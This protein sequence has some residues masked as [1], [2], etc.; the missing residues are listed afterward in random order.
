MKDIGEIMNFEEALKAM[1]DGKKVRMKHW[2]ISCSIG[3]EDGKIYWYSDEK[4][5]YFTA[6]IS[7]KAITSDEWGICGITEE[8]VYCRCYDRKPIFNNGK[9]SEN[10]V[11][12]TGFNISI[13]GTECETEFDVY[14]CFDTPLTKPIFE[15]CKFKINYCPMCGRKL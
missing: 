14:C 7:S 5:G 8:C 4:R 13:N 11:V 2:G 10:N 9:L 1:R 3:L 15:Q 12:T 6:T